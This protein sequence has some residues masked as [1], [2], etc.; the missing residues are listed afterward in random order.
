MRKLEKIMI[1]STSTKFVIGASGSDR[2]EPTTAKTLTAA[3]RAASRMFQQS[4]GGKI[5]V[6][7]VHGSGDCE[8]VEEVAV[9]HGYSA[10]Q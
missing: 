3:K 10:W 5:Q 8:R 2:W 6:G 7:Q 9:K 1:V 4:A